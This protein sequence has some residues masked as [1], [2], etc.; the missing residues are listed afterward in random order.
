M[1]N[2]ILKNRFYRNM[3]RHPDL[4]WEFIEARLNENTE[5]LEVLRRMEESGGEPDT[6][7]L[8]EKRW[9]ATSSLFKASRLS[10]AIRSPY[11]PPLT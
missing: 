4:Q 1:I 7:G 6:I 10:V 9:R 5:A 2:E 11:A 8:D 3:T